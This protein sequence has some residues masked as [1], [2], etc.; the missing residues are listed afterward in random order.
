MISL[1]ID[2][3][4][5]CVGY[6]FTE[7]KIILSAGFVDIS[8]IVGNRA[9]AWAVIEH[10]KNDTLLSTVD[11][12]YLE[13]ALGGFAGPS[14]RKVIVTLARWSAVLEYVLEEYFKRP[15]NL[16]NV[17]TARKRLFGKARESGVKPKVF[18]KRELD[19]L[20]NMSNWQVKNKRG[21]VDK[22]VEDLYDAVVIGMFNST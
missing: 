11:Q 22:R 15:I 14:S 4:T 17:S 16:V 1:G 3:S 18:V 19:K 6:A 10:L 12:I 21:N 8:K 13:A 5:T 9:K 20:Y 2:A 7:N